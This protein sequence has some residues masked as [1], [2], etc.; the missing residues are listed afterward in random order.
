MNERMNITRLDLTK[1]MFDVF[2][3]SEDV[4]VALS[5]SGMLNIWMLKA[6]VESKVLYLL[7]M[8]NY[9]MYISLSIK[10]SSNLL[11]Q[12]C[13]M[14]FYNVYVL[15]FLLSLFFLWVY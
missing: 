9:T 13:D 3:S 12:S 14:Q 4:V 10:S 1:C 2:I 6:T 11:V 7:F 5:L 15:S 8:Y